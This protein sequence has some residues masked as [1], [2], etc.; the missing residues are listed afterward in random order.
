MMRTWAEALETVEA[1][2]DDHE[3]AVAGAYLVEFCITL[4]DDLIIDQVEFDAAHSEKLRRA[5]TGTWGFGSMCPDVAIRIR[6]IQK[7]V[8]N[9]LPEM[10]SDADVKR[11]EDMRTEGAA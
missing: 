11:L 2:E 7:S 4:Y 3:L 9:P 6:A 5:L 10:L 8:P 1:A